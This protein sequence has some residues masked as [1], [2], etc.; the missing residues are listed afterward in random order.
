MVESS[1][2]EMDI[3]MDNWTSQNE[4]HTQ[5]SVSADTSP[6]EMNEKQTTGK[7]G[8]TSEESLGVVNRSSSVTSRDNGKES[9]LKST[10]LEMINS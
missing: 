9:S 7:H 5:Q 2:E 10:H 8:N 6:R 3:R 1:E 4:E